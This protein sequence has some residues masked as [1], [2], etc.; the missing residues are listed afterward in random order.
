MAHRKPLLLAFASAGLLAAFG[1]FAMPFDALKTTASN[2]V[3]LVGSHE[4]DHDDEKPHQTSRDCGA[5]DEDDDDGACS[6][7]SNGVIDQNVAP[8]SNGLFTPGSKPAVK[9]N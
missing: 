9:M 8:P 3:W 6:G 5:S 7:R 2:A 1:S 4:T